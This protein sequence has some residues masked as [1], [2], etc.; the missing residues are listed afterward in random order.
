[1][2]A[3]NF[4][5]V[6]TG[7]AVPYY[8]LVALAPIVLWLCFDWKNRLAWKMAVL[9]A[10]TLGSGIVQRMGDGVD[11]NA[12]FEFL[13]ALALGLGLAL[14][15]TPQ[16]SGILKRGMTVARPALAFLLFRCFC[17]LPQRGL[18][19]DPKRGFPLRSRRK[20]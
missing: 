7:R 4:E 6:F 10:L 14:N 5:N 12:F 19:I 18:H 8:L 13:F 15:Q 16:L 17:C 9:L 20:C 2:R 3:L 11:I 1:M